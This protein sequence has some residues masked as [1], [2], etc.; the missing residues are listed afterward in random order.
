MTRTALF[1]F[2]TAVVALAGCT[3]AQQGT[4]TLPSALRAASKTAAGR[5]HA[6]SLHPE[7]AS[8]SVVY[9]FAGGTTD[10]AGPAWE[11][12]VDVSGMLYG[13]TTGGGT[14]GDGTVFRTTTSG[15]EGIAYSFKPSPDGEE[16]FA[17][18][19][20]SARFGTTYLGGLYGYG[21]VF[22]LTSSGTE[23]VL[24][25]FSGG[26]DGAYPTAALINVNGTLME[27]PS[28]VV[29]RP[30]TETGPCLA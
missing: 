1:V 25:N 27:P 28:S 13:T 19:D 9:S 8:E 3:N 7:L 15:V 18:L 14:N 17:G 30:A 24:H 26:T 4:Q 29:P 20:K 22:K 12:L 6:N 5:A 16:P 2:W 11:D 23:K 21:T 10:G